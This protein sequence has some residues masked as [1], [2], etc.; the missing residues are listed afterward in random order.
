MG[1]VDRQRERERE[2]ERGREGES[3]GTLLPSSMSEVANGTLV[4]WLAHVIDGTTPH[5]FQRSGYTSVGL[6]SCEIKCFI[7][8]ASAYD[9]G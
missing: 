1:K 6:S 2:R 7:S 5:H 3:H 8:G 9:T 4:T